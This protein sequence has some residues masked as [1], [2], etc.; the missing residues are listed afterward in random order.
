[1][2][3]TREPRFT[4]SLVDGLRNRQERRRRRLDHQNRS[5]ALFI[6]SASSSRT[7]LQTSTCCPAARFG[8]DLRTRFKT[9]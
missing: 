7:R 6:L 4:E 5:V 1:M 3:A 8:K 2:R 9:V